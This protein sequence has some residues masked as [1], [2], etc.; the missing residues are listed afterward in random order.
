MDPVSQGAL[1]AAV[2][3]SL[4]GRDERLP[5]PVV[6]WLGAL[7]AMAPDLDVLIRSSEDSL[8][9]IE[10]HRHFTHS[11]TFV[12]VGA[13]IA[14]LP[15]LL[16]RDVRSQLWLA[17]LI[18]ACGYLTHAPLDCCTT[19]GTLLFWPWSDTRL[20]W[21]WVSV[22]DPLFTLP[23]LAFVVLAAWRRRLAL[24][25][26]G[27]ALALGYLALGAV[28][29]QRALSV[30]KDVMVARGHDPSRRDALTT[31]MNQV[32]WRS[33]Y[34]VEGRIYVD[35]IRVPYLGTPCFKEGASLSKAEPPPTG[36]GPV[37][38]RGH[39][40]IRW[41]SDDWVARAP[42]DSTLLGDLRY[43]V[44]PYGTTPFWGVRIDEE[45]DRA[46]WVQTGVERSIRPRDVLSLIFDNPPGSLCVDELPQP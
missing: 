18:S 32:T 38:A 33:L 45:A 11:L 4:W 9:A 13:A 28:Q 40:L 20:A 24:A 23:L 7:S 14:L 19:Y 42:K 36:L 22:V 6:G 5:T 2:T 34:E 12:P 29:K 16:R 41:F 27:L 10:Y 35:Q 21:S 1:G 44:P 30:Q 39:R 25:R 31:F 46:D 17:W 3:L 37:A 43:A 15:W 8:L 26:G